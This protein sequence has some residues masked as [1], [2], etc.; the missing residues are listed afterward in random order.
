MMR[1]MII[2]SEFILKFI[3]GPP[4]LYELEM[5]ASLRDRALKPELN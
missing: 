5:D 4:N 3:N 2:E 1:I